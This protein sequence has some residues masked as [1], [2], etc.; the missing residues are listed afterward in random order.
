MEHK[1]E[2]NEMFTH[3]KNVDCTLNIGTARVK[4]SLKNRPPPK[5]NSFR[6]IL[7]FDEWSNY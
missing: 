4:F 1:T 2:T 3:F 5:Q 6:N 7:M